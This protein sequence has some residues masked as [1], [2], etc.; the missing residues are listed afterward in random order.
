M[1]EYEMP[2][3][4]ITIYR[5]KILYD[6][7]KKVKEKLTW[8]FDNIND[9]RLKL[10]GK[11]H[12]NA[13]D[14][15]RSLL[16][17][18]KCIYYKKGFCMLKGHY[19]DE[20]FGHFCIYHSRKLSGLTMADKKFLKDFIDYDGQILKENVLKYVEE[21]KSYTKLLAIFDRMEK[22]IFGGKNEK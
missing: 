20:D 6:G 2:D 19:V 5:N 10:T 22:N 14:E 16:N 12:S 7:N 17:C 3:G 8:L 4:K 15:K 1:K 18:R 13:Y 11:A 21:N 9:F